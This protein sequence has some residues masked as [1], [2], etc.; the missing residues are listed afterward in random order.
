[1]HNVYLNIVA[2]FFDGDKQSR[3]FISDHTE[4]YNPPRLLLETNY[5]KIKDHISQFL[6]SCCD[7]E[8]PETLYS[9]LILAKQILDSEIDLVYKIELPVNTKIY[10][11]YFLTSYNISVIHPYVRKAIQYF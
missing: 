1:M 11:P 8:K 4:Q 3:M 10:S 6:S 5:V 9:T 7:V 2:S